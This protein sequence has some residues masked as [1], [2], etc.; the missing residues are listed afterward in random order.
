MYHPL[1]P[2][3]PGSWRAARP[4]IFIYVWACGPVRC[5]VLYSL[6]KTK[7]SFLFWGEVFS[8]TPAPGGPRGP[9]AAS[10]SPQRPTA[11]GVA[12]ALP[13]FRWDY[14]LPTHPPFRGSPGPAGPPPYGGS[15][16]FRFSYPEG[17]AGPLFLYWH[18]L[19]KDTLQRKSRRSSL[20]LRAPVWG[21]PAG[22][23]EMPVAA[24]DRSRGG[25]AP[26]L[27]RGYLAGSSRWVARYSR[28]DTPWTF[29]KAREKWSWLS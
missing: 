14:F 13:L 11:D 2:H 25:S 3:L 1:W 23:G 17:E 27:R 20:R 5:N 21:G 6:I 7:S 4:C 8:F 26:R 12:E 19:P 9:R 28:G 18:C 24:G 10:L 29:L 15:G 22:P 16:L